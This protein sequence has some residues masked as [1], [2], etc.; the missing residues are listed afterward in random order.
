[1]T[2][3]FRFTFEEFEAQYRAVL[4]A[5]YSVITCAEYATQKHNLPALTAIN[6]VDLDLSVNR[7]AGRGR[8]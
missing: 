8:C 1:M 5:G 3:P 4:D 2:D 7:L 6:R